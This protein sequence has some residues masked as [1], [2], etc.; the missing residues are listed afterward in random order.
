MGRALDRLYVLA[1]R[2]GV[3]VTLDHVLGRRWNLGLERPAHRT[4]P[5]ERASRSYVGM[6]DLGEIDDAA[7]QLV[8][9][10]APP[11]GGR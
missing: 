4:L 2:Y 10:L 11:T 9:E 1:E 6:D 7:Q 3:H 8:N 5:G